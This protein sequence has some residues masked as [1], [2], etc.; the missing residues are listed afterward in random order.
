M[1]TIIINS[2]CKWKVIKSPIFH[3]FM[4]R[5]M[6]YFLCFLCRTQKVSILKS[7]ENVWQKHF[8]LSFLQWFFL[9]HLVVSKRKQHLRMFSI[10]M[11]KEKTWQNSDVYKSE[12]PCGLFFHHVFALAFEQLSVIKSSLWKLTWTN[13]RTFLATLCKNSSEIDNVNKFFPFFVN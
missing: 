8:F 2:L 12:N 3:I 13:L 6:F 1:A 4:L 11:A 5:K 9:S 7:N 10:I